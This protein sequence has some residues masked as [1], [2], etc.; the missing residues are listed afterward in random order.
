MEQLGAARKCRRFLTD[1]LLLLVCAGFLISIPRA[2]AQALPSEL[3][4]QH[5]VVTVNG[6]PVAV[7]HA[8]QNYYFANFDVKKHAVVSVTAERDDFWSR[9]VEVQPWRLG[10]RPERKG[11]TI[12]FSLD[13]PAKISITRPGDFLAD[14]EM[15]FLFANAPE[16]DA[17]RP[18]APRLRYFG[19]GV[20]RENIS[21]ASGDTIYLAPGAVIFGSL[22]L[23]GVENVRIF[24][25]GIVVYDGPQDPDDDDGWI[26]QPNWHCIVMDNARHISIEGITCVVR[27][28]TWMI[29]M[30]DSRDVRFDNV[31]VIGGSEGNANQDGMD[32]LGGGDT[33]VT[34]SFFRAADDVFAMQGNWDGYGDEAMAIPGH[35]V[36][37]IVVEKSVVSTSISNIVRA[38]WP[39][40]SFDSHNFTMRDTDVLH[41]GLGACVVPFALLEIWNDPG[42][43]GLHSHYS[44]DDV[45]L[46]DWYSLVQLRQPEPQSGASISDI[47]LRD[48]AALESPPLV[49]S[50]L[51]GD[52]RGVSFD[53][54]TVANKL[55]ERD[56]DVPLELLGG[57]G[58]PAYNEGQKAP[59]AA[60]S[61]SAGMLAPHKR[62]KF[63][64]S[65][66]RA[67]DAKIVAYRWSFGDGTS[68]KGRVVNHSFPDAE[69]TLLDQSGRFRVLVEVTDTNGR[70]SWADEPVV[71]AKSRL[72]PSTP[73]A[74]ERGLAYRYV[75]GRR[76]AL[77]DLE[78]HDDAEGLS[79]GINL[80]KRE[81]RED[82]GL[83]FDGFIDVPADGGY[84]F[85]LLSNDAASIEIDS[86]AVATSAAPWPHVCHTAGNAV[87]R[88]VGSIG[89]GAGKHRIRVAMTHGT[90]EDGFRV[91]WQGP[92]I[93]LSDIPPSAL[94]HSVEGTSSHPSR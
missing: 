15:L 57:A 72:A 6:R 42:G 78:R 4:T 14:A 67:G 90:G 20:Y 27:S 93:E 49:P 30:K 25:R 33:I 60:F 69:G 70:K 61:Y 1:S 53:N 81:R 92:G 91:L 22:N 48:V 24:G 28:R 23:W 38:G 16:K 45:R 29:Q 64:A 87:E 41:A 58:D 75:E 88:A 55:T 83:V 11:R 13:G 77:A 52:V 5:F 12:T 76:L 3:A 46:E 40:K 37:N 79:D 54:V 17:P 68:A 44:F 80:S 66:T 34:N 65:A 85:T 2:N 51:K 63:D 62:V 10:I 21:P 36:S 9:G 26:H 73:V 47:Q 35:E 82:Y 84:T 89:L 56:E 94:S 18:T 7:A 59:R 39:H 74:T 43:R 71:V 31:K 86:T 32:W 19:T 8:A 50:A